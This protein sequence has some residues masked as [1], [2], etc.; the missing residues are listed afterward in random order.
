M[1]YSAEASFTAGAVL[2]PAGAY[3]VRAALQKRPALLPLALVPLFFAAQQIS[4]GFVW[5]G[6]HHGDPDL[7]RPASLV[8]LFFALA[9]WP[10]WFPLLSALS[11]PR[12]ARRRLFVALTAA[13]T[14][15]FWV[16]FYPL[17]VGPESLLTTRV[18]HH[19]VQ[20]SITDLAVYRYVPRSVLR[21]L[22]FL[23]VAV[24]MVLGS[25]S[26]GK[27][28]G[29]VLAASAVVAAVAYDYAF[30]SVWCFF[31]AILSGY[32]CY[33][34]ATMPAAVPVREESV[35]MPGDVRPIPS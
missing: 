14:V 27:V 25:E 1:C 35:A 8:F 21:V 22:Y 33:V 19:S 20:Y 29:L 12:R 26:I 24:P 34:F 18:V 23:C 30:A 3:C 7:V 5:L 15:W 9:F 11:E 17:L 4:E 10:F 28:P 31:A 2:L 16:L 32:L 13:A 6:L